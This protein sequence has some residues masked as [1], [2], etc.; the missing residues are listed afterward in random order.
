LNLD[1][2]PGGRYLL[3]FDTRDLP[4]FAADVIVVGG[5]VAGLSAALAAADSARVL[6]LLKDQTG[7]CNT[8]LAQGGIA[9][10]IADDDSVE[11]HLTDTLAT[12]CGLCDEDVVRQVVG[13]APEAID[14]L[15][16]AGGELDRTADGHFELGREA[17]HTRA[18]ILHAHGDSTGKEMD[19]ALVAAVRAHARIRILPQVFMIDLLTTDGQCVGVLARRRDGEL[20]N[21]F[22]RSV[23]LAAGGAGRLYRETSNVRAATGDGIAAAYRAG[24][25]VRDME[26]VQFHPTTLYLA[27]S[28]RFLITEAVRGEGAW[29]VDNLGRRFL[30]GAHP[31]AELAPRDVVSR[32]IVEHLGQ[33]DV[34]DVFLDMRHWSAG[35]AR[36]RFPGL[37]SLCARY[38]ID[39]SRDL[40][41]VRPAAHF[42]IGG[43]RADLDGRTN[44]PGLFVCGE[45][46]CTGLHGANRLASNSLLEGLVLGTRAGVAAAAETRARFDG[47]VTHRAGREPSTAGID[48]DDLRKALT[49]RMWRRAGIL[50]DAEGLTEAVDAIT[51]WRVFLAGVDL[52]DRVAFEL[53]NLLLLGLLVSGGAL[54]RKESRGTHARRD[55]PERDDERCGGTMI[56]RRGAEPRFEPLAKVVRG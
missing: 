44:L 7:V 33:P 27:G 41:P 21:V 4:R 46:A 55:F 35:H 43:V 36:K 20:I 9:A 24:A 26:F 40:V 18:R 10:A 31:A 47:D 49:S 1:L 3:D 56:W 51:R 29:I 5:G 28:E 30:Q 54:L 15:V 48:L 50:R 8:A 32:A 25:E 12:G 19:R 13:A 6:L 37:A 14:R 2:E 23:V 16:R 38:G 52:F 53:E 39:P 42:F 34:E 11:A 17:G 45:T 22:A